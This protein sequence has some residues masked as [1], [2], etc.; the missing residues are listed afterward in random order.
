MKDIIFD[1]DGTLW[2]TTEVVAKAWNKAVE[3]TG[4]T[5]EVITGEVLKKEFGRPMN[6]IADDLF[7][8]LDAEKKQEIMDICCQYEHEYLEKYEDN[9][10]YEGMR[11]TLI[12]LSKEHRI[13]IVSN[14]QCG[15]IE[16][17]LRKTDLEEYVTDI[18]CYGNTKKSKGENIRMVIER[19]HLE[20]PVY[21]GDTMGDYEASCEAGIPFIFA[22]YGFGD[23]AGVEKIEK[24]CELLKR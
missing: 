16:Q 1:V 8:G 15:Y 6:V 9:L 2:D 12:C 21:V 11:E 5:A 18:E 7:P 17:F 4:V 23:V 10:C 22:A 13:C 19:N 3:M 20:D 14:C 24:I